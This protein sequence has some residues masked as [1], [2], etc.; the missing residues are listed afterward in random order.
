MCDLCLKHTSGL[1]GFG[2]YSLTS[3]EADGYTFQARLSVCEATLSDFY[4]DGE[5]IAVT[6]LKMK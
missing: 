3:I 2:T 4:Q 6:Q 1:L 5:V